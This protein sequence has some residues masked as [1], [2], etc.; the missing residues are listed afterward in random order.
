MPDGVHYDTGVVDAIELPS[1]SV[2]GAQLFSP[3]AGK[4]N[5]GFVGPP[6]F[7]VLALRFDFA[8]RRRVPLRVL[9]ASPSQPGRPYRDL[10][11]ARDSL[12][13]DQ[14]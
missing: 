4:A 1:T 14:D 8:R 10:A 7:R 11:H 2:E 13:C 3:G 5:D 6:S 9:G 12:G